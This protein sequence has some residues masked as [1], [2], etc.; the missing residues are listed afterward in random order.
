MDEEMSWSSAPFFLMSTFHGRY[1]RTG[2]EGA[3]SFDSPFIIL[4]NPDECGRGLF[5]FQG[6]P[7]PGAPLDHCGEE[8][9]VRFR[10]TFTGLSAKS[11]QYTR[12]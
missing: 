10:Q 5:R 7:L 3:T 4:R 8:A 6:V 1:D 11:L 2:I 12:G 9:S